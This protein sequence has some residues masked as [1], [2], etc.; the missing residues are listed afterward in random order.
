MSYY[1]D[2]VKTQAIGHNSTTTE[3]SQ[4]KKIGFDKFI[5]TKIMLVTYSS[6]N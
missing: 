4:R 6:T 2:A 1:F 3:F 5:L